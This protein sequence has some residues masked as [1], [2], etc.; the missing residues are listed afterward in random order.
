MGLRNFLATQQLKYLTKRAHSTPLSFPGDLLKRKHVLVCLPAGLRELTLVKQL[1]P[2]IAY[3]FKPADIALL[4]MPGIRVYDIYPRKGFQ[5]LTPSLDQLT[6]TGLPKKSYLQTLTDLK[7]DMILDMNLEESHFTSSVLL[8]FPNAVRIGRG[9]HLGQPYYNL[10]IKTKYLRDE[11]NIYR[12]LLET[13]G[14]IMNKRVDATI[15]N[16]PY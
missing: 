5:I 11:R 4:S 15:M 9:N 3:L 6:W 7:F 12:S 1:L 10:E 13:L 14:A 8:D 16:T 2:A